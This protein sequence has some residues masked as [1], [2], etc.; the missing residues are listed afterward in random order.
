[1]WIYRGCIFT[2]IQFL[3]VPNTVLQWEW[4]RIEKNYTFLSF[5]S[6]II[7]HWWYIRYVWS[8]IILGLH[9]VT[10]TNWTE[11]VNYSEEQKMHRY[12]STF[13]FHDSN[14]HSFPKQLLSSD[15]EGWKY[16]K[17]LHSTLW[18]RVLK[19][20]VLTIII[21]HDSI[22]LTFTNMYQWDT[23]QWEFWQSNKVYKTT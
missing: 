5:L 9:F 7:Y 13:M 20:G 21:L 2:N 16:F 12:T 22:F 17:G 8:F 1:M 14:L 15:D 19:N 6:L 3:G 23:W 11:M 4:E 18:K 10:C